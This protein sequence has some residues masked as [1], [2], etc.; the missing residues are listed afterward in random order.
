MA[1]GGRY[2]VHPAGRGGDRRLSTRVSAAARRHV[3]R[4]RRRAY[5]DEATGRPEDPRDGVGG[6][7]PVPRALPQR[8]AHRGVDRQSE[9]H[10][11]LRRGRGQRGPLHR[12]ALRRGVG[13]QG[14][15]RQGRAAGS[16]S[17]R[18]DHLPGRQRARRCASARPHPSRH[19]AGQHPGGSP[20][21]R[22]VARSR[23]PLGL[24]PHEAQ[25]VPQRADADRPI[26][27]NRR[28]RRPGADRG[29]TGRRTSGHL[30]A[31]LRVLRM[32]HRR[33][34]VRAG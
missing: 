29:Q 23:L 12:D 7:R 32:P 19:Q 2:P 18:V 15:H 22:S 5:A 34:S 28:L 24:R 9:H 8:I 31:R 3:H 11:D 27:G 25:R 30:L 20:A 16:R 33:R 26:H 6:R 13:P 1:N 14:A 10:P 4:L 21:R 17:V